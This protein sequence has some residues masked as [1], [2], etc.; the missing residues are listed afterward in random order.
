MQPKPALIAAVPQLFVS[1]IA[2]AC[3]FFTDKLGFAIEFVYGEP[4]FYAQVKRDGAQIALRHLDRPVLDMI[5]EAMKADV[6]MLTASIAVDDVMALYSEFQTAG[7]AFHQELRTE[8][9]GARTFIVR[10]PDGNL[11]LF[12]GS[13]D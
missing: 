3:A 9:W 13:A 1:D 12:T 7:V 5:A 8:P 2:A 4:P 6:D 10:D 11:L